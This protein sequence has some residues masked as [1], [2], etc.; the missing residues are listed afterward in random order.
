MMYTQNILYWVSMILI[1]EPA[2]VQVWP[3]I[4]ASLFL[5]YPYRRSRLDRIEQYY[6][7]LDKPFGIMCPFRINLRKWMQ[8]IGVTILASVSTNQLY[9]FI[10]L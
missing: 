10:T 9:N 1:V 2:I 7:D 6:N 3:R 5:N 8:A 4:R